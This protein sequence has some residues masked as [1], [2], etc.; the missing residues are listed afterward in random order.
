M[1]IKKVSDSSDPDIGG[2]VK[3]LVDWGEYNDFGADILTKVVQSRSSRKN[4]P[5]VLVAK[6]NNKVVGTVSLVAN[7]TDL[8]QDLYPVITMFVV[9]PK[10]RGQGIGRELMEAILGFC[11]QKFKRVFLITSLIGFYEKFGFKCLGKTEAYFNFRKHLTYKERI[12][13]KVF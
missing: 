2:I 7:D 5:V 4:F 12:Y 3:L 9:D 1:E 13:R 8:R 11:K 10:Y 6:E